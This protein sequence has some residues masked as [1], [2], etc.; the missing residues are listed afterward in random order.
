MQ[1]PLS[2]PTWQ[3]FALAVLVW[4]TTWHAI[5]YQIA[6]TPV[7]W[8]VAIRFAVPAPSALA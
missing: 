5:V 2:L 1:R 4:G 3:L 7:V 6:E 8:G